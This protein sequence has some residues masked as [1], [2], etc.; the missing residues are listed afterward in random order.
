VRSP[1]RTV[2]LAAVVL[3]GVV[4]GLA[5]AACGGA[6]VE[7]DVD[8]DVDLDVDARTMTRALRGGAAIAAESPLAALAIGRVVD[9]DG[10]SRCTGVG[11]GPRH[12]ATAAHC[13]ASADDLA[14]LIDART[15]GFVERVHDAALADGSANGPSDGLADVLPVV[16]VRKHPTLDIAVLLLG[17]D[18]Q[19]AAVDVGVAPSYGDHV[20]VAGAGLGTPVDEAAAVAAFVVDAVDDDTLSLIAVDV[21]AG[22][23]PGDSGAPVLAE[24]DDGLELVGLHVRGFDDCGGPSTSLRVDVVDDFFAAAR[25]VVVDDAPAC[26]VAVDAARCIGTTLVRCV[27]GAWRDIPCALVSYACVDDGVDAARCGPIPCGDVSAAGRCEEGFALRCVGGTLVQQDCAAEPGTGCALDPTTGRRG[28]VPCD[29]C[30]GV[31][32]DPSSDEDHCGGCGQACAPA[33][34]CTA[35]ICVERPEADDARDDGRDDGVVDGD[36][37][38]DDDDST[39]GAGCHGTPAGLWGLALLRR[40]RSAG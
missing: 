17:H 21:G 23:C 38:D 31:C 40:R 12:V 3:A 19:G 37:N 36:R 27:A 2:V 29:A 6:D 33:A 10:R 11:V 14:G 26:D 8:V 35:G 15:L 7:V 32:I 18:L 16:D 5:T 30:G 13:V 20:F 24:R 39:S 22:L 25:A 9:G 1:A 4:V 28:C 34:T